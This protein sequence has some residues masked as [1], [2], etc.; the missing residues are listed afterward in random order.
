MK[1]QSQDPM[2]L[3]PLTTEMIQPFPVDT[4]CTKHVTFRQEWVPSTRFELDDF[5]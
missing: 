4:G 1:M 3:N 2:Y 5:I